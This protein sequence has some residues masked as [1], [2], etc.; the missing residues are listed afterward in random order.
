MVVL[1]LAG[2]H[3]P[4]A[5]T[6]PLTLL[7]M[8]HGLLVPP[9]LAGTVGL[10]PALAGSA[11]AVAGLMQQLMGAVG[12]YAV[13]LFTHEDARHLGWLMLGLAACAALA[14]LRLLRRWHRPV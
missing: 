13:G 7:G 5:F 1:D 2:L 14:Q 12:G 8:G 4:L 10:L 6:L 9:T 3:T 11:A